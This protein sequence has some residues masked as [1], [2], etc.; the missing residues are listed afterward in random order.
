MGK[1]LP[2]LGALSLHEA[3]QPLSTAGK[4]DSAVVDMDEPDE[5]DE[6]TKPDAVAL[7]NVPP[8][9]RPSRGGRSRRGQ[10]GRLSGRGRGRGTNP[11]APDLPKPTAPD[12]PKPKKKV[13]M[14]SKETPAKR[15]Q[16]IADNQARGRYL[17]ELAGGDGPLNIIVAFLAKRLAP[18]ED[19]LLNS[20]SR[21][22]CVGI[23]NACREL[24]VFR[25]LRMEK[26]VTDPYDCSNADS[27][28]WK[29][30]MVVF[31]ID[32]TYENKWRRNGE[33]ITGR[34]YPNWNEIR[35]L[36][37]E[38]KLARTKT[39]YWGPHATQSW[40]LETAR[41]NAP[42]TER[43]L[44]MDACR[45]FDGGIRFHHGRTLSRLSNGAPSPFPQPKELWRELVKSDWGVRFLETPWM[46]EDEGMMEARIKELKHALRRPIQCVNYGD[47]AMAV[48]TD[49]LQWRLR[50]LPIIS[51]IVQRALKHNR[52]V[53]S[54]SEDDFNEVQEQI[55]ALYWVISKLWEQSLPLFDT[56]CNA[57]REVVYELIVE[58]CAKSASRATD[59]GTL[60]RTAGERNIDVV[61]MSAD[62][63]DPMGVGVRKDVWERLR[64]LVE[65]GRITM[66]AISAYDHVANSIR[67]A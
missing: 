17:S 46:L 33:L 20:D 12:P 14:Y 64:E 41:P 59:I 18:D 4:K 60:F 43:K 65:E 29:A 1:M 54:E 49:A 23:L 62:N 47:V 57:H 9:F 51:G 37:D 36:T 52:R 10:D 28:I 48:A 35:M 2:S 40:V 53:E 63:G 39:T 61:L 8:W 16:D 55:Y 15:M 19:A 13:N 7:R 30:A 32:P 42:E 25:E 45:A 66:T 58:L 24:R 50:H 22:L 5:P 67:V 11:T 27:P 21:T 44:F 56:L 38:D 3:T 26:M 34:L 6:P 31:G